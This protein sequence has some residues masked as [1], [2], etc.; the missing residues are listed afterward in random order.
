[1]IILSSLRIITPLYSLAEYCKI[2]KNLD[3]CLVSRRC[4]TIILDSYSIFFYKDDS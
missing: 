2:S 4:D 3:V 1:M